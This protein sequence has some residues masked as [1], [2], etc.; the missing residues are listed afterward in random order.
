MT[1]FQSEGNKFDVIILGAGS[2]GVPAAY[3]FSKSGFKTLVIDV[4]ASP[5]QG[6]N[7]RAIGGIRATHSDPAKIALCQRSIQL[8]STWRELTGDDIEWVRGGYCFVAYRE[9]EQNSLKDLLRLQKELGLNIDWHDTSQLLEIV[10]ELNPDGL[11]G[12]TFSP[13]DGNASPLLALLSFYR[14]S[15]KCGATYKFHEKVIQFI[16]SGEKIIGVKTSSNQYYAPV[17]ILAA[18][19][20]SRELGPLVDLDI[21]V[22]P[23]SHEAAITEPVERFLNPMIV[24]IRPTDDSSNFYFYQ[25]F[26]GQI[27]F[28]ITPKPNIWGTDIRETSAFLPMASQRLLDLM[29]RLHHLR[30]RRTWRGLYPMTPDGFPLVGLVPEKPGLILATGMC[31]QGFM[32]GPGLAELLVRL[33]DGSLREDDLQILE[34]LN[35]KRQFQ[36]QEILK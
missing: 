6:S 19:G 16:T 24:D 8:F 30:V 10:P 27:V 15:L 31:G 35:P 9:E 21:P 28:C 25:H 3:A 18:G 22:Y 7:K 1:D 17:T 13:E 29:P 14:Q 36:A 34:R 20:T 11:L 2:I 33:V 32:L 12:G 23:D 4:E 5:G 26:T